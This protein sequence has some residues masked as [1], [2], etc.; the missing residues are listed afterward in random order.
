MNAP[1]IDCHFHT[2]K[3]DG[4]YSPEKAAA[5]A[6]K[7]ELSFAAVT[8]HDI[9]DPE[10]VGLL[11]DE[12]IESV[13]AVE[14]SACEYLPGNR[15][16]S[17]HV[18]AFA[19]EFDASFESVLEGVRA[20]RVSKVRGQLAKLESFGFQASWEE[21]QDHWT[22]RGVGIENLSNA[23]VRD[24]LF[25]EDALTAR[26]AFNASRYREMTGRAYD[27]KTFISRHLKRESDS[28]FGYVAMAD[29]E[30][31]FD[32]LA[33]VRERT[34]AILSIAHPNCT[35]ERQGIG[36]FETFALRALDS[37]AV[38]ALEIHSSTPP[39]WI[40]KILDIRNRTDALVTF[41]SDCHFKPSYDG[42]HSWIGELNPHVDTALVEEEFG[43]FRRAL[44]A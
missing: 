7:R 42:K 39:E 21:F 19:R 40:G 5:E 25:P 41:G 23:H 30:P 10:T 12:G 18:T 11:R 36:E 4:A 15:K 17:L 14:I 8:N 33:S 27:P 16:K 28:P 22:C 24:F 29:Y 44:A 43:R 1:R 38:N 32:F 37:G 13:P 3:S 34:G 20:A 26:A 2:T 31:G 6:K 35:F 9:L